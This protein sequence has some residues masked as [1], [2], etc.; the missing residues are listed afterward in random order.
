[1]P[2]EDYSKLK[3]KFTDKWKSLPLRG[4]RAYRQRKVRV[5]PKTLALFCTSECT[6]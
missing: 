5:V 6:E 4:N 3:E 1:M 2:E